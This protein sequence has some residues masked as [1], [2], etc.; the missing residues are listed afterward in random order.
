MPVTVTYYN[1]TSQKIQSG[2][3]PPSDTYVVNLYTTLPFNAT[4]T[5]KTAAESGATQLS[6]ANGYTQNSKALAGVNVAT[7]TTNDSRL[8]SDPVEWD[9]TGSGIA[10]DYAL[11]YSDTQ[12]NDP[13]YAHIDFGGTV[14]AVAGTKF[15]I[16]PN[17]GGITQL[18]VT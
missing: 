12:T 7:V 15:R 11:I 9:A 16:T 6:T 5:T 8:I 2:T 13:P 18:I 14:T 17:A 4:A 1:H 3:F 10:A